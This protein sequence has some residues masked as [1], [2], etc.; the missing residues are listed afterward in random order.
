MGP[1]RSLSRTGTEWD[2]GRSV[3]VA[4]AA[5]APTPVSRSTG[6]GQPRSERSVE[7]IAFVRVTGLV[8]GGEPAL[9]LGR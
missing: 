6:H 9:A 7:G 3:S 4:P 8:A 5:A 2:G 1:C